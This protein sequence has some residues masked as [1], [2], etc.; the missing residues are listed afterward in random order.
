M[1]QLL[2]RPGNMRNARYI[3]ALSIFAITGV[4]A[5][6]Q[7]PDSLYKP[8]KEFKNSIKLNISNRI[9]YDNAFQLSYERVINKH[10]TLNIF[11]GY[12][13]FPGG[14]ILDLDNTELGDTKKNSGY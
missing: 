3:I 9:L 7:T 1:K 2:F 8:A 12:Q 14:I 10:Q 11:G 6:A 13:E 4:C 5:F